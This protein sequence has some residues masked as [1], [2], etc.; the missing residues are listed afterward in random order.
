MMDF[1]IRIPKLTG[2][3]IEVRLQVKNYGVMPDSEAEKWA[4]AEIK[5]LGSITN[6]RK[7]KAEGLPGPAWRFHSTGY[8]GDIY[9]MIALKEMVPEIL[10]EFIGNTLIYNDLKEQWQQENH[11]D[12][13]GYASFIFYEDFFQQERNTDLVLYEDNVRREYDTT[14]VILEWVYPEVSRWYVINREKEWSKNA[15]FDDRAALARQR[16]QNPQEIDRL[17]TERQ[18]AVIKAVERWQKARKQGWE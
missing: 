6:Q 15:S 2:Q 12:Y 13:T 1:F 10:H 9:V 17:V 8:G 5:R 18:K 14:L 16:L 7:I 11:K 4:K 3:F